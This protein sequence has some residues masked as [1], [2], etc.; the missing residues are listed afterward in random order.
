MPAGLPPVNPSVDDADL[1]AGNF[2][3][4]IGAIFTD[5]IALLTRHLTLYV[6]AALLHFAIIAGTC[7]LVALVFGPLMAG[8][9]I[10][11][12]KALKEEEVTFGDFF[13][14][15]RLFMPLFLLTLVMGTLIVLGVT[16]CIL[17]GIYLGVAWTFALPLVIDRNMGWWEAMSFSMKVVNRQFWP[18]LLLQLLVGAVSGV[19]NSFVLTSFLTMPWMAVVTVAAY[20][21]IFGL[22]PGPVGP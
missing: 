13:A 19:L 21:R 12:L 17:P 9:T 8:F 4:D 6:L 3:V 11:G 18:L 10:A 22:R 7:G 5:S 1:L 14:G 20:N 2:K 15:F 16:A